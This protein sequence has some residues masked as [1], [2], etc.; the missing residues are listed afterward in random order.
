[1]ARDL[2]YGG[3]ANTNGPRSFAGKAAAS[4]EG[5]RSLLLMVSAARIFLLGLLPGL[6]V[7]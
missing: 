3:L 1:M 7:G 6:V 2:G 4:A 5:G